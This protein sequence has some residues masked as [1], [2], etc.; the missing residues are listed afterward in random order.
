M[1]QAYRRVGVAAALATPPSVESDRIAALE[2]RVSALEARAEIQD[3]HLADA[4]R[5]IESFRMLID[6]PA[7]ST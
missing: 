5:I 3:Q 2:R 4:A 7:E 1:N 6:G